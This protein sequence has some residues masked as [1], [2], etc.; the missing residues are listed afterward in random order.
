MIS[1]GSLG[2]GFSTAQRLGRAGAKVS[3]CGRREEVLRD[4]VKKLRNEGIEAMGVPADV[5]LENEVEYWFSETERNFGHA[6]ILV[7]NAGISGRCTFLDLDEKQW[8]KTIGVNC[9]GPFLCTRRAI[10]AMKS[11]QKGRIIFI[12][13][14]AG[15]YYRH[16]Y[17]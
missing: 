14:I 4:A 12:S 1:G 5:S 15:Q 9:R 2:M 6:S 16:V 7:N 11:A 13:S 8:D 17:R 3:I 10:P